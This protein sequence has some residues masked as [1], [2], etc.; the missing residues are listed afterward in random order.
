MIRRV[1]AVAAV[2][3]LCG[4]VAIGQ[5][6]APTKVEG[7]GTKTKTGLKYWDIKTGTGAEAVKG[8]TVSVHYTGW[9]TS[10]GKPFDSSVGGAPL[11]FKI[12]EGRVIK[13]WE[14]GI[15]GMKVGGKRQLRIP[16]DLAY[17]E[18]GYPGA[19]PPMSTLVFDVEL[20]GV[21]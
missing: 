15:T 19:I 8:S 11:S 6:P 4:A 1:L 10:G 20:V 18:R 7:P 9:F 21:K 12:G 14:E 17:G 2:V 5:V 16:P 3:I 13:G